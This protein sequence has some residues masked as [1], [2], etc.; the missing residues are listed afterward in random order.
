VSRKKKRANESAVTTEAPPVPA[1][2]AAAATESAPAPTEAA[3]PTPSPSGDG[4][5]LAAVRWLDV[6][7]VVVVLLLAFLVGSFAARNSDVW[8]HLATGRLIAHGEYRFGTDPFSYTTAGSYWVNRSWFSDLGLYLLTSLTGGPEGSGGVVAVVV[9]ALLVVVLAGLMLRIRRP[10]Q[11]LWLPAVCVGLAI[12]CMAPRLTLLNSMELSYLFLG[13]TLWVLMREG[14][15][16][17]WEGMQRGAILL[18][19]APQRLYVLPPLFVLWVN[20]DAWFLLGPAAVGLYFLGGRGKSSAGQAEDIAEGRTLG[21][22]FLAGLAACLLNPHH[23]FAF[24]PPLELLPTLQFPDLAKRF[25]DMQLFLTPFQ[26]GYAMVPDIGY[27]VAGWTYYVM[28]SLGLFSFVV[29]FGKWSSSRL[30]LCLGFALLSVTNYQLI[31]FF[32]IVAGPLT[33]LNLQDWAADFSV[34][35]AP[36]AR[37]RWLALGGRGVT[38]AFGIVLLL[39]AWPGWLLGNRDN[40]QT[41]RHVGWG[42]VAE[43]S[44]VKLTGQFAAWR[45]D[46]LLKP[47]DH[48]IS[49]RAQVAHYC[50]WFAPGEKSFSDDRFDLFGATVYEHGELLLALLGNFDNTAGLSPEG[51]AAKAAQTLR[52]R[53][54]RYVILYNEYP[55]ST[56]PS[57]ADPSNRP[58]RF[59]QDPNHWSLLYLDGRSFVFGANEALKGDARLDRLQYDFAAHAFGASAEH[60]PVS[61]PGRGPQPRTFWER[62]LQGTPPRPLDAD[63]AAA[64]LVCA[65]ILQQKRLAPLGIV[66]AARYT[67]FMTAGGIL[68]GSS[69]SMVPVGIPAAITANI[70]PRFEELLPLYLAAPNPQ[71][72]A[73]AMLLALRAARRAIA[74]NPDDPDAYLQLGRAALNLEEVQEAQWGGDP[75][76]PA[77]SPEQLLQVLDR[78]EAPAVSPWVFS[79]AWIFSP[80]GVSGRHRYRHIETVTAL[81]EYLRF[82][83]DSLEAR[84]L[85]SNIYW[86]MGFFDLSIKQLREAVQLAKDT[87]GGKSARLEEGVASV[88]RL[89]AARD[90]SVKLLEA[91]FTL[92]SAELTPGLKA[93]AA[94]RS[95]GLAGESLNILNKIDAAKRSP[96]EQKLKAYLLLVTGQG[97]ELRKQPSSE[98][99]ELQIFEAVAQGDLKQ[100]APRLDQIVSEI[101][102]PQPKPIANLIASW[103]LG[104]TEQEFWPRTLAGLFMAEGGE[105]SGRFP[106]RSQQEALLQVLVIRG[107]VALEEGDNAT[108]AAAFRHALVFTLLDVPSGNRTIAKRYLELL[109]AHK[110]D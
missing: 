6:S 96:E 82:R 98:G 107:L 54:I 61:G 104:R 100:V 58:L 95:Y 76:S 35:R 108:A 99:P 92:K 17:P 25:G 75:V 84:Q 1:T 52:E 63:A 22:V 12:V 65:E 24:T 39:A 53:G 4:S 86:R 106:L 83:P 71:P 62:Y 91:R 60:V 87:V 90:Q 85:L 42:I 46:G 36:T 14:R 93:L 110:K 102:A 18:T 19:T 30:L 44:L 27:H 72:P 70:P 38:L 45:R 11:S 33:A 81:N 55:L 26:R 103:M 29:S 68:A 57:P 15:P 28:L 49:F 31:P 109:D 74:E 67:G 37:D 10:G 73:S 59:L 21:L 40:P 79:P 43:P 16:A 77:L 51:A 56:S 94:L 105:V 88:E 9:K 47:D 64:Y 7:L 97:E 41:G 3:P 5:W 2:P 69:C 89:L 101:S 66:N 50:A 32:A 80:G 13:S 78:V 34:D 23:I 48:G 8:M 20:C